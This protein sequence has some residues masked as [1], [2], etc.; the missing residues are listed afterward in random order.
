MFFPPIVRFFVLSIA[1]LACLTGARLLTAQETDDPSESFL[2]AFTS[3]QQGEKLEKDGSYKFAV[4][5]Y[6]FAASLLEQIQQR[7]PNWQPLIVQYRTRKTAEAIARA[8]GRLTLDRTPAGAI[9]PPTPTPAA[10]PRQPMPP[11]RDGVDPLPTNESEWPAVR[12]AVAV[13]TP[14]PLAETATRATRDA[15]IKLDRLQQELDENRKALAA[16]K[17]ERDKVDSQLQSTRAD[18]KTAQ[19]KAERAT[20]GATDLEAQLAKARETL[21]EALTKNPDATDTRRQLRDE[22]TELKK[23]VAEAEQQTQATTRER[24]DLAARLAEATQRIDYITSERDK[25]TDRAETAKDSTARI[26]TL[27]ASNADL[28]R[29][30]ESAENDIRQLNTDASLKQQESETLRTELNSI[31]EQLTAAKDRNDRS[32]TTITELRAQLDQTSKDLADM[33]KQ[34][35]TSDEVQRMTRENDL[36]RGIVLQQLKEQAKREQAKKLLTQELARLEIQ[37]KTISDQVAM[38]GTPTIQLNDEVR[39]L[40]RDAA[41]SVA[42]GGDATMAVSIAA[43]KQPGPGGAPAAGGNVPGSTPPPGAPGTGP[44]VE[45]NL[46]PK[47]PDELLPV[48][49]EMKEALDGGRF[50]EAEKACEKILA[51]DPQNLFARSNLGVSLLRQGKLKQSEMALKRALST[52]PND[53]FS[54]S[55]LGIVYSR[56]RRYDDAIDQLTKA[57][58]LDPKSASAHNHLGIVAGQKGWPEA[59]EQEFK[60]AITLNPNYADAHFN[61]AVIYATNSPPSKPLANQHYQK[62]TSLGASPDSGL[63]KLIGGN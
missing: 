26:E 12:R 17:D 62:A 36:L 50:I 30:L 39:A 54:R 63:E 46:T 48:A 59:A 14:L 35:A 15:R 19:R 52:D 16:A 34:G 2:K 9:E 28:Q 5:K 44:I 1:V 33:R 25:A 4:S 56:M 61:L 8:E 10:L 43:V 58:S 18:L 49:R 55:S 22:V 51:R 21:K 7:N 47:V 32:E 6:R 20:T 40:F 29:K 57:I 31:R 24:E 53:A 27:M 60:K 45:T 23:Q 41:I 13:S 3:V 42:D 37:S 11:S 38:L